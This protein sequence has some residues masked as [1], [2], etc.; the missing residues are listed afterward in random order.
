MRNISTEKAKEKSETTVNA[1]DIIAREVRTKMLRERD[2]K[3]ISLVKA[4]RS[5][6][7]V[8]ALC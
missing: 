1:L 7:F 4:P 3:V 5:V 2:V 6:F 8:P